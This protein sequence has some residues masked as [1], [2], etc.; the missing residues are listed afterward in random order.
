VAGVVSPEDKYFNP[1]LIAERFWELY[2]QEKSA[3]TFDLD[4]LGEQ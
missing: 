1:P 3:W 2:D 4:I